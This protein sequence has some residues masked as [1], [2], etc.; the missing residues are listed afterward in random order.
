[1]AAYSASAATT[2][3]NSKQATNPLGFLPSLLT[4]TPAGGSGFRTCQGPYNLPANCPDGT[5]LL[6]SCAVPFGVVTSNATRCETARDI[7]CCSQCVQCDRRFSAMTGTWCLCH[8]LLLLPPA[9]HISSC[10]SIDVIAHKQG[11]K[12]GFINLA[13]LCIKQLLLLDF[14]SEL[15]KKTS[16]LP[17]AQ[18]GDTQFAISSH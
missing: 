15:S 10:Y 12:L 3:F 14:S 11:L 8:V 6:Y 2:G 18:H 7:Q 9:T 4:D 17:L 13:L 1:M 16:F 5:K